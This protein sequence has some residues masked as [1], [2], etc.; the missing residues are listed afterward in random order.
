LLGLQHSWSGDLV[1][2]LTYTNPNTNATVS[3][4]LFSHIGLSS[5]HPEGSWV[6]FG[7][8]GGTGD[9]YIF[10][11]AASGS[12]WAVAAGLGYADAIPGVQTDEVNNGQYFP[13][14]AGGG[15][16]NFSAAFAGLDIASGS[17]CLTIA[18]TNDHAAEGSSIANNGSLVGWQISIQTSTSGTSADF[19][20]SA[21]PPSQ[22]VTAGNSTSYSVNVRP[23]NGFTGSV[24][25]TASGLPPGASASFSP[26]PLV[27]SDSSTSSTMTATSNGT[28]TP[29]SYTLNISGQ[30]ASATHSTTATLNVTPETLQFVPVTPCRVA[31]TRNATGPFGGPEL[32][33]N[34]IRAFAVR[35]SG[36][37]IPSGALAYSVN[38]TVVPD[39]SL[40]YLTLWPYGSSQPL[41]STLNSDGRIKANAAIVPAGS[42]AGGSINVY[43][44]D[45]TQFILDIDGYF[46]S[47]G[48]SDSALQFYTLTPCRI[49]DT[50]TAN[51][52]LGGPYIGGGTARSFPAATACNIPA[53]ASAYSLNLT[54]V[55]H[56]PLSYITAWPQGQSMPLASVLNAPTGTIVANAAIIP[57]GS[58]G[59]GISVY[60]S[61]DTDIIIDIDGYF[62]PPGPGGLSLYPVAP[63][64]VLDTRN[65]SGAFSGTTV[66]NVTGSPGNVNPAAQ[67]YV[68]NAT[69]VPSG[70]LSY[71]TLWPDGQSQPLVSTLNALDAAITSNMAIVATVNGKMD[72]YA[73]DTT[74]QI[75]D[76]S[77]Y[78]AP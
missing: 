2:T 18:D 22:S 77:A 28:V 71:L 16:N 29:A 37:S 56:G 31:D 66:V 36:C 61:D 75:L 64:R 74:Q 45:A 11:S 54:A 76:I 68:F 9:N 14:D 25:L 41:V 34:S 23:I 32:A 47:S 78:F 42:D 73:T 17:W 13:T 60:A 48:S 33:G 65:G 39:G 10:S 63:Y 50:R 5:K 7:T 3:A 52:P 15:N 55:P 72:T 53:S 70:A 51:G 27:V 44:T 35:N 46:V 24:T 67:A 30:S 20:V 49:A 58:Q 57:A 8:P 26:N 6:A 40:G 21:I 19:S 4:N 38:A 12:M 43:V 1:A 62:A 59:G 69:V